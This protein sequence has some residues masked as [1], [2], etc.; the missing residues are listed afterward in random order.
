MAAGSTS[1]AQTVTITNPGAAATV[2]SI[3]ATGPYTETNTCGASIA[4]GGSCTVSVTFAPTTGGAAPGSL[5]VA[6]S[7][8]GSPLTVAL[9]GTGVTSTTNLALAPGATMTANGSDS[10]FP[11]TNANDGNTGTYWEGVDGSGYPQTLTANLGQSYS[12]GSVTLDLPPSTAWATRTQTFSVLGSANDSTWT[13]LVP[14]ATYTFNPSTGNTVTFS[15]PSG[16]NDQYLE[17]DFSANSGW[18][19][20][21]ISEF[22]VFPGSGG[23]GSTGS[24]TLSASPTSVSFASQAVGSTSAP[25][26]V[27]ISNTGTVAASVSSITA[28]SPF[29]ETNTCGSS[30]T[31][32]GS[33]TASVTFTPTAAGAASA[34]LTVASN[35]TDASLAVAL[36]GTGTNPGSATL[37]ASPTS[38]SFASQAIGST[39][40]PQT[41][42]IKNTGTV[43][44]SV[45]SITA[46]SPFGE[47]NTCGSSIA[48][49]GSCTASVTFT[50]TAAGAAS[51]SLTVA[52]NATDASLAVALSGTGTNP[53]SAT[54]SASPTSVSFASQAIGS[55]SAAQTVTISNTG[56]AAASMSSVGVTGPFTEANNC[57]TS[58]AAGA[59]CTVNV[60]FAPTAA[61][62]ATGTLSVNS[63]A[64]G[65][66]LTVALS[67]TGTSSGGTSANLALNAP[68][69]ASST[70]A[71]YP[72]GNANDGNT[73][74]Y[75]E[76]TDGVWPTTLTTNLGAADPITS[77][78]VDLPPATAWSTRTQTL[79]VLGS[80]N[81]TTFT[82]IVPSATYTWNPSTGNTVT[83]A[84]PAG[85]TD[86]YVQLSFTANSV[87]NGAQASE[88]QVWGTSTALPDLALNAPVTA[89]SAT[90]GYP[91]TNAVDGNTSTYWEGTNGVWPTTLT[92]NLGSAKALS[93][94]VLDL[95]PAT[96][97]STRTQ[98][99]SVLGS[100]NGTTFTTIV[101][102][103]TYTW[104]PSTGNTVTIAL[105]AGTT[106][107]YVQLSFTANSVQNGAQASEILIH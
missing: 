97:W 52:S 12:V 83:I 91:A 27:T 72:A 15:L 95:P 23:G 102:S 104:N 53:G 80:A 105:P 5:S 94:V 4:A 85:T 62:S 11:A 47:T 74:T 96:A 77:V 36:S 103:A 29:G 17:L 71:G 55:T 32:G 67:G 50:P 99:L 82:T 7:A 28:G 21:Q 34:S 9:S 61:G 1:A 33:C 107:Q 78:V 45:S 35:A 39:S 60:T 65:S 16:T 64:P 76:G 26:T 90:S 75:W 88:F 57:G 58:L 3:S 43:A 81:G 30:I 84:L 101:P 56:T 48:A 19:A 8:P 87:Q 10:G 63:S 69:T 59:T 46:G 86:Q 18:S 98:T 79:S 20:A 42:T 44:A 24:A 89:S 31:A 6:T 40:A 41:V 51:A 14:S 2:S 68:I 54:L 73:S 66:P 49:G 93:Q 100:A 22:E 37:S 25:Q 70:A 92:V 38:V 13:T 106:D